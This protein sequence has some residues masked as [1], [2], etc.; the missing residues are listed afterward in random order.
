VTSFKLPGIH[1]VHSRGKVYH[2]HR[3]SGTRIK[4]DPN[5]LLAFASEVAAIEAAKPQVQAPLAGSLGGLITAYK[6]SPEWAGLAPDTQK[7]YQ[8]AF[9]ALQPIDALSLEDLDSAAVLTIR[10]KVY[11]KNGRWLANM[12]VAVLSVVLAWGA[13]RKYL[14]SNTAAG[15]PKIRRSRQ[16][17]VANKS[18]TWDEVTALLDLAPG[19]MRKGCA[20][21]YF[22]GMRLKDVVETLRASRTG[23]EIARQSSKPGTQISVFATKRLVDILDEPDKIAGDTIVVN[24]LGEPY[25]RDGF[26]TNFH[27]LKAKL[28]EAGKI[29]KGLT[30]HG[31]RKSLGKDAADMGFSENDIAGALGQSSPASARPYTVEHRQREA[32]R[33]VI[34]ALEERGKR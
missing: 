13:P 10:D 9:N 5:D 16:L 23:D 14:A 28:V 27:K 32:A 8:R 1:T 29:R 17:G 21:A 22:T 31:L 19:G 34:R 30:F 15:V 24:E 26:K 4:A 3:A 20:L 25:T 7:S 33:K 6:R 11:A 2:Y 18:W 12:V